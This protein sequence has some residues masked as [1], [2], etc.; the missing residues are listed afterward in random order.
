MVHVGQRMIAVEVSILSK[1][2]LL[3]NINEFF[4]RI[5]YFLCLKVFVS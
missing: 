4:M 2:I 1:S 5:A 3:W